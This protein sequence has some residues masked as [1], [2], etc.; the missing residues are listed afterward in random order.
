MNLATEGVR[1]AV[2]RLLQDGEVHPQLVT[3]A[4]ARIAGELGAGIAQAGGMDLE[5]ILADVIEVVRKAGRTHHELLRV[6][7]LPLA[8]MRECPPPR[9]PLQ[10]RLHEHEPSAPAAS[11]SDGLVRPSPE[12]PGQD[13]GR[14]RRGTGERE[15]GDQAAD[16][17]HAERDEGPASGSRAPFSLF[18]PARSP[19]SRASA[20]MARV[21]C[22]CQ[23]RQLLT[24]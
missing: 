15:P 14:R 5:T 9:L 1:K 2:L 11:L 7:E 3:I 21:T 19:A 16:L 23:P 4:V 17:G 18:R 24:S 6:E 10:L 22:R 8:G 13:E 20:S 12:G